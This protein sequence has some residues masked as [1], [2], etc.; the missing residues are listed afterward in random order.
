MFLSVLYIRL[1]LHAKI[2]LTGGIYR[3]NVPHTIQL[4]VENTGFLPVGRAVASIL[5]TSQ[6]TG[7]ETPIALS[8]P[9]PAKNVTIVEFKITVPHCGMTNLKLQWVHFVDAIHLFGGKV[10]MHPEVQVMTLPIGKDMDI[11]PEVPGS[12]TDEESNLYSKR[13]AGDDPS[14]VYRIREY[15]P[16]DLQKRIHWK[17]SCR[18]DTVWVKEYSYPL[19]Q[20]AAVMIDYSMSD[21]SRMEC[22]DTMLETAYTIA[23]TFLKQDIPVALYWYDAEAQ[24]LVWNE[25]HSV[26]AL[27]NSFITLLSQVPAQNASQFL[28][29]LTEHATVHA[30]N[31]LFYCTPVF[32][33]EELQILSHTFSKNRLHILT[34][35]NPKQ[36]LPDAEAVAVE[37]VTENTIAE[38]LQQLLQG[39]GGRADAAFR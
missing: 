20:R 10:R 16:G 14:E 1:H 28:L 26:D 18:T 37:Y 7:A 9:I 35:E 15:Q 25:L 24:Q 33:K 8:F 36:Q 23:T 30:V 11:M 34:A 39:K 32:D 17:L 19:Q 4:V 2:C 27:H 22:M 12:A 5:C 38:T 13:K 6:I 3:R 29:Q 31:A 21:L